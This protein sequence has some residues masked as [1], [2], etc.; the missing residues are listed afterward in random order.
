MRA[1]RGDGGGRN[2]RRGARR[3]FTVRGEEEDGELDSRRPKAIPSAWRKL[4]ARRSRRWSSIWTGRSSTAVR[5][6][7]RRARTSHGGRKLGLG[8]RFRK[9]G[10]GV[11]RG[12]REG[13]LGGVVVLIQQGG[14]GE[15]C[16][17]MAHRAATVSTVEKT[18]PRYYQC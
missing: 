14:A 17:G 16:G 4:T 18:T 7:G 8:F 3:S 13:G 5:R 15:Q 9:M 1:R 11:T 10:R 12:E 6:D 2:R